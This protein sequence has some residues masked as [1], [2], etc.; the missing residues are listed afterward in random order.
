MILFQTPPTIAGTPLG[1]VDAVVFD[2]EATSLDTRNAR[3]VE[4][5]GVRI[6]GGRLLE[7]SAYSGLINPQSR[8]RDGARAVHGIDHDMIKDA[9]DFRDRIS[10]FADWV[11]PRL[12]LG[13]SVWFDMAILEAEFRRHGLLWSPPELIDVQELARILQPE[14][15]SW[16]MESVAGWLSIDIDDRHRAL[17]DAMVTAD[18]FT[19][20]VP[21][22]RQHGIDTVGQAIRACEAI[23]D[24]PVPATTT[25]RPIA[26]TPGMGSLPFRRRV[27]DIM[28]APP[29]TV[30]RTESLR[31]AIGKLAA[32]G[33]SSLFVSGFGD[34]QHGILT[35]SDIL[36]ALA[37]EHT[38]AFDRPV[39]DICSHPLM[40]VADREFV[41][42]AMVLMSSRH[43][44]HLGVT[45]TNGRLVGAV[46][47]RDTLNL[48]GSDAITLG[49]DIETARNSADL[50]RIWSELG[51][52]VGSLLDQSVAPRRIAAIISRELRGLTERAFVIAEHEL[53]DRLGPTDGE[54]AVLVLGSGGRGE[55]LLAMDQDNAIVFS[56]D[57]DRQERFLE[58]G[59][60]M[61]S[62]LNESGV[63][64]CDGGVM[65]SNPDWCR[66][67]DAWQDAVSEWITRTR[68]SDRM[69]VDIFFDAFPV[70]GSVKLAARLRQDALDKAR[71]NRPFIAL[72]ARRSCDIAGPFGFLQRWK[73]NDRRRIDVKRCGLMPLFSAARVL[74]LE[75]GV[76]N[77]STA[78]RLA[79]AVEQHGLDPS[80]AQDLLT[81]HGL[82]LGAILRQQLRDIEKG[83]PLSSQ[84]RPAELGGF[85][86]QELRWALQQIPRVADLLGVPATI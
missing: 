86:Q 32:N 2:T 23:R 19:R 48:H 71:N 41:Y 63:R 21:R 37:D 53:A 54:Y 4:I 81:A 30:D 7:D 29:L 80:L 6:A 47:A 8:I 76:E 51:V 61:S 9:P 11:G 60:R 28:S 70:A 25:S 75:N 57:P 44:R 66:S 20:L 10:E 39:E 82:L 3:L 74:A 50:G 62:I 68:P 78:S 43:I 13:Y 34:E 55:S 16:T 42:R 1:S 85:E 52:V 22:L 5:A 83:L 26:A 40:T 84:V 77:R 45:D 31:T 59:R 36:R 12:L 17:P 14:I 46:T 38:P 24:Q 27:G 58:L 15:R 73:L 79:I 69:N 65:A 35:E 72:L 56:G 67:I 64:L 33:V 18:I 49:R